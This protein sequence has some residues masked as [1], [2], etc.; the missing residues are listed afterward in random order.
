VLITL[1]PKHEKRPDLLAFE[2]YGS[3]RLWWLFAARNP[4]LLIDPVE[5]FVAGL[6]IYAPAAAQVEGYL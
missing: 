5:D 6:T 2:L 1:S 3:P 4:D